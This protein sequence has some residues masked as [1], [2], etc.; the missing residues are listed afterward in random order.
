M[1]LLLFYTHEFWLR[2]FARNLPDIPDC[3]E[4]TAVDGAVLALVHSEPADGERRGKVVTRAI[5]NIKWVAGKFDSKRVVLHF[6]AHLARESATPELAREL[7]DAMAQRLRGA[8]YE[9]R[10]TPFGWFNEFRLH[11]AGESMGKVFV[12]I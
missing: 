3:D 9:V 12:E 2:P 8:G 10:V 5:K 6:F 4:E 1:K 7:V 11:V